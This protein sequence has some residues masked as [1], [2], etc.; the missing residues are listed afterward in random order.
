MYE[1]VILDA[2]FISRPGGMFFNGNDL[3]HGLAQRLRDDAYLHVSEHSAE[4]FQEEHEVVRTMN[5]LGLAWGR[6][7][8]SRN[9]Q[10]LTM[11]LHFDCKRERRLEQELCRMTLKVKNG[12]CVMVVESR[13]KLSH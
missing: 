5:T 1:P 10:P 7:V 11:L 12:Q 3:M 2:V 9:A 4:I 6:K 8:R 13:A